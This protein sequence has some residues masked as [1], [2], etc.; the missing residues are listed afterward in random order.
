MRYCLSCKYL[1]PKDATYCG[2]CARSFGGR[3]CPQHHLSPPSARVCV[4][5]GA[6]ELTE[7]TGS[8]APSS[9]ARGFGIALVAVLAISF[10]PVLLKN[11]GAGLSLVWQQIFNVRVLDRLLSIGLL[12][13]LLNFIPG[14]VGRS[15]RRGIT[16]AL[17]MIFS[18]SLRF[19][20]DI[21]RLLAA[22]LYFKGRRR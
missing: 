13:L 15:I 19:I 8:F 1:S 6:T 12:L 2:H 3:R 18:S 7:A 21:P 22:L 4:Q 16:R 14:D 9:Y 20:S 10:L 17:G 5:C 11:M